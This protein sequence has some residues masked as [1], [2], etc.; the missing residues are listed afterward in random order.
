MKKLVVGLLF[1]LMSTFNLAKA[2]SLSIR[3]SDAYKESLAEIKRIGKYETIKLI[4]RLQREQLEK[5]G[6]EI[7]EFSRMTR[8]Y[9]SDA[10]I[11]SQ[12]IIDWDKFVQYVNQEREQLGKSVI[13]RNRVLE[14]LVEL[15]F[16]REKQAAILC[17]NPRTLALIEQD[18]SYSYTYL[19]KD[20]SYLVE[21]DVDSADCSE[22][23]K[24]RGL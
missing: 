14:Q 17:T 11:H 9:G 16:F 19:D 23:L 13:G 22:I 6:G 7:D 8:I 24:A 21:F 15:D 10:G 20:L 1:V 3:M 4:V 2:E 12:A 18:V 5:F